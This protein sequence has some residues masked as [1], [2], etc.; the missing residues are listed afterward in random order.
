VP[1]GFSITSLIDQNPNSVAVSAPVLLTR[2]NAPLTFSVL[3]DGSPQVS[4]NG[5]SIWATSL[6]LR[7]GLSFLAHLTTGANR[8]S[9]DAV[10]NAGGIL[11]D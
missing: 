6:R 10:V 3:D 8:M 1:N 2:L 11:R 5:G 4:S 7:P 9:A